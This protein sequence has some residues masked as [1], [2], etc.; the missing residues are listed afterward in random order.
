MG[1]R[2]PLAHVQEWEVGRALFLWQ[3]NHPINLSIDGLRVILGW[4]V[5][6]VE[7]GLLSRS[8]GYHLPNV[9]SFFDSEFF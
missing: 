8:F 1:T 7:Q 4:V 9:F 6:D 5:P 3:S 2:L